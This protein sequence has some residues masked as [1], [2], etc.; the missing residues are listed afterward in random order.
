[1]SP[2]DWPRLV[3]RHARDVRS[4]D[5]TMSSEGSSRCSTA[6]VN[7]VEVIVHM[8]RSFQRVLVGVECRERDF[9]S[10]IRIAESAVLKRRR[11]VRENQA[12]V[13]LRY[14]W[15][16]RHPGIALIC[17]DPGGA[18]ESED[19]AREA[20]GKVLLAFVFATS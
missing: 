9:V 3:D 14:G 15:V 7:P 12:E 18:S 13:E 20:R 5:L 1:M 2:R 8:V 19:Q 6:L 16:V 10:T 4:L 11:Q 17:R